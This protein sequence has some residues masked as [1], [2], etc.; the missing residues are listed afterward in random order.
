MQPV[1]FQGILRAATTLPP[2]QFDVLHKMLPP[3]S[4]VCK[5]EDDSGF[6]LLE[7][8]RCNLD[9][10]PNCSY[11]VKALANSRSLGAPYGLKRYHKIRSFSQE[12]FFTSGFSAL[13]K[14]TFNLNK[15]GTLVVSP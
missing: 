5:Q 14:A 13:G 2:G 10:H 8:F 7:R 15:A 12:G 1:Q 3:I 6:R 4:V 11:G 9:Q